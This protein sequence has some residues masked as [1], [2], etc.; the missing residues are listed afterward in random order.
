MSHRVHPADLLIRPQLHAL[1]RSLRGA[2]QGDAPRVHQARVATR[3]LREVLPVVLPGSR[4]RK[5]ERRVRRLGRALG[6]LRELDVAL[7]TLDELNAAD[8]APRA[9]I[10]R[11]IQVIRQERQQVYARMC[12]EVER[13][14]VPKLRR[15]MNEAARKRRMATAR[16][17]P[18]DGSGS[19]DAVERVARRAARLRATIESAGSI[20]LSDRLHE[21]RVAVKKLRYATEV[22]CRLRGSRAEASIR[23][24][25]EA[26]DLLGRMHDL[27]VLIARVRDVQASRAPTL[28]L[29]SD[30]DRLVRR[31]EN[32]CRQLHGQYMTSRRALLAIC[33]RAEAAQAR[34]RKSRVSSA[35]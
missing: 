1:T 9:G 2:R 7:Q 18:R 24:L 13:V 17:K 16:G 34:A 31:L 4:G 23:R 35:A 33:D 14:D 22:A 25:K 5:L 12:D 19:A 27:E 26:Q 21:V 30:L 28:R 11:L 15:R 8:D 20:Y 3:R 6:P 32:E 10:A 29:S